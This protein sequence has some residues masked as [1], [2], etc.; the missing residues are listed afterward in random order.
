MFCGVV[1]SIL[2]SGGIFPPGFSTPFSHSYT[3]VGK[4]QVEP[5]VAVIHRAM[6]VGR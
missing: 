5:S 6:L 4:M 3:A 2:T 1:G